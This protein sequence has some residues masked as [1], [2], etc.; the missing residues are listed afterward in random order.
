MFIK[1]GCDSVCPEP[2]SVSI[3][4]LNYHYST[5]C[6]SQGCKEWKTGLRKGCSVVCNGT[7][8]N[9]REHY[10]CQVG[11]TKAVEDYYIRTTGLL[12]VPEPPT[13]IS[14]SLTSTSLQLSWEGSF[15]E[16]PYLVFT[17]QRRLYRANYQWETIST[18]PLNQAFFT[19]QGLKPYTQYTFRIGWILAHDFPPIYSQGS[20]LIE[21]LPQGLPNPPEITS[22]QPISNSSVA[23][24]WIPPSQPNG[25]LIAYKLKLQKRPQGH[26]IVKDIPMKLNP[27]GY[28]FSGLSPNTNYSL[29]ISARNME[30]EGEARSIDFVTPQSSL[31]S[32]AT[33]RPEPQLLIQ[34]IQD[35]YIQQTDL[36]V[37]PDVIVYAPG[38]NISA[39]TAHFKY[40]WV[41][42]ATSNGQ[43]MRKSLEKNQSLEIFSSDGLDI[44]IS[45]MSVDWLHNKLYLVGKMK[46]SSQWLIKICE[47]NGQ[48]L[49]TT[50]FPYLGAHLVD[51]I[52][53]PFTGYFYWVTRPTLG[54][55]QSGL[56]KM[57]MFAKPTE[58]SL[59]LGSNNGELGPFTVD[60]ENYRIL[61]VDKGK[62]TVLSVSLNGDVAN[63]RRNTQSP[64]F[65]EALSIGMYNGIFYW[66]TGKTIVIE[67][68]NSAQ[69]SFYQNSYDVPKN[70]QPC[71]RLMILHPDLQPVPV[72]MAPPLQPE[73]IMGTRQAR[74]SWRPPAVIAGLGCKNVK[75]RNSLSPYKYEVQN[76]HNDEVNNFYKMITFWTRVILDL[77]RLPQ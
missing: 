15:P 10:G 28:T 6:I 61:I 64:Q 5:I 66:T 25:K 44:V 24:T 32:E 58:P 42:I 31:S 46:S 3:E 57:D 19:V 60:F 33:K 56:F 37:E 49:N 52:A 29:S 8:E 74:V 65:G 17:I 4:R 67:E 62:N 23:V 36:L 53:D 71:S 20:T 47:L 7:E 54:K 35:V 22:I 40:K 59:V 2:V 68:Y 45:F 75:R 13:L 63:I 30:G 12:G 14:D 11:C 51:F 70:H 26:D 73:V 38:Q 41:Y 69:D 43:V 16:L 72:P 34:G 21:T 77:S 27:R 1:S 18:Q 48:G 76:H 9:F 39:I 55:N 50:I